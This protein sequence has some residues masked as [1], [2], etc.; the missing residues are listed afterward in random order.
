MPKPLR[1]NQCDIDILSSMK[2][3]PEEI[4]TLHDKLSKYSDQEVSLNISWLEK[5]SFIK[6]NIFKHPAGG[7]TITYGLDQLGKEYF[8]IQ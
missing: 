5:K 8:N 6:K 3:K 2:D 7:I 4:M 1:L